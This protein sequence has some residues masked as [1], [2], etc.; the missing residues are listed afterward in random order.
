MSGLGF[1][2]RKLIAQIIEQ[3]FKVKAE[4]KKYNYKEL[5]FIIQEMLDEEGK[6]YFENYSPNYGH[7]IFREF[8]KYLL[9]RNLANY[10]SMVLITSRKG[11]GKSS[12]AIMMAREWCKLI[13]IRFNPERHIAYNNSDVM[14]KIDKLNKFEPIICVGQNTKIRIKDFNGVERSTEV[15][16]LVNKK[17]YQVLTYNI[18]KDKFEYQTP[19]KTVLTKKAV[20]WKLELENG[21]T[22]NTT[23]EHLFLTKNRGYVQL[24]NLTETDELVLQT[25]FCKICNKEY[26]NKQ[27]DAVTCSKSCHNKYNILN[28]KN[29]IKNHIERFK[30]I[31]RD[32]Y[33]EK[34]KD[35]NF[36]LQ[37]NLI[38]RLPK[39]MHGIFNGPTRFERAVGCNIQFF[40]NYIKDKLS[41]EMTWDNYG[42][43][44][45]KWN[46]DH[47]IPVSKLN[48]YNKK[49][50]CHYTNIQPLW[51]ILNTKKGSEVYN[52][53]N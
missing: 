11:T 49:Q 35:I 24:Q 41:K 53:N 45:N 37:H 27:W 47:I 10:D 32:R 1:G 21:V 42:N 3:N 15:K 23:P 9:Y 14:N 19:K 22:I 2:K 36:K 30:Q 20:T 4:D 31:S 38:T 39:T 40:V 48:N 46:L 52:D 34:H 29:Y 17:N 8:V 7:H 51:S 44:K 33:K 5:L 25:K 26:Y 28:N 13:G 16:N 50:V 43:G 6:K 12:A 18:K